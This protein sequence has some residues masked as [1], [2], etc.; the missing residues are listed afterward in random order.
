MPR[1][2]WMILLLGISLGNVCLAQSQGTLELIE[3]SESLRSEIE[4]LRTE[5]DHLSGES[6]SSLN[7][8][9]A[10][11][12]LRL[13]NVYDELAL[14]LRE[15]RE[16]GLDVSQV[17]QQLAPKLL[18]LGP[19]IRRAIEQ[20]QKAIDT[21]DGKF[22]PLSVE[23]LAAF[24]EHNQFID[25]GLTALS[26]HV[27]NLADLSLNNKDSQEFLNQA[28][29][30]RAEIL[31]GQVSLTQRA[32][33]NATLHLENRPDDADTKARK[34]AQD[35]KLALITNS[36][37]VVIA[38]M[39]DNKLETERYQELLI[40]TTGDITADIL[41][42][43]LIKRLA[44]AWLADTVDFIKHNGAA[45]FFKL[46]VFFAII[47]IFYLLSRWAS[48]LLHKSLR[49]SNVRMSS[50][51]EDMLVKLTGRLVL[52]IGVLIGLGQLG[53]SVGPILA[54]LGV[55]GFIVGFALQDTL[56]NFASG[57]MI[58]IY[59]PFDVDDVIEAAG[60]K[61]QV[62]SMNL[63]STT[64][65]TFDNQ[66]LVVPNNKIWGDVIRNVTA[67]N[68]RRVDMVF[69]IG[70]QDDID[71]AEKVLNSILADHDK[72]LSEPEPIVRLHTL[73]DSSVDFVVRPW[74]NT[75]DYWDVY[76]DVTRAVKKRF[77]AEGISIPFPQRDVHIYQ[78][79]EK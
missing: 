9:L 37:R 3:K 12:H 33:E 29:H 63:V 53:V 21:L 42:A 75:E 59:R 16:A 60:I 51:M 2:T 7:I 62:R 65:L 54:G 14:A 69:G 43:N 61:G 13:L 22:E 52:F 50:L 34:Q 64:I 41:D 55:A 58:L 1:L 74:V 47:G 48:K 78:T 8:R 28:L 23:W 24:R 40:R 35:E 70:Y 49:R 44:Q 18:R 36:L 56:G 6:Q 11:R 38:L 31:A 39:R 76:W 68:Q 19:H 15:D 4:Q 67:Q 79:T 25:T 73:N 57:M 27:E 72:V 17:T 45:V 5:R 46:V 32:I 26:Q 66:T 10:E 77:D 71:Q 20:R 30:Q